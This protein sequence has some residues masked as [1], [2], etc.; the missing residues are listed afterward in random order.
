V[1]WLT[2]NHNIWDIDSD[3][4]TDIKDVLLVYLKR[5]YGDRAIAQILT[6]SYL[7]GKSA[8]D[9][10]VMI[11]GNRD[12]MD[13]ERRFKNGEVMKPGEV[14][15]EYN[16][17]GELKTTVVPVDYRYIADR[18]KKK[19]GVDF[20][21]K[22]MAE[23][24]D[25]LM[26]GAESAIEK[27]IVETA[28]LMD[29]NLDH[30]GLHAA[31]VII[32]D[33]DDLAEYI[34]VAWDV[35]F[36]TWKTQCDMVQCES[37]HGLLKMDI[38]LLKTLDIVTYAL[39]L[40][41]KNH[42]NA[43]IDIDNLPFEKEVFK[44][45]YAKG[46][47]K[48]V[49][50]FE[51]GGMVKFL[52]QLQPTCIED[53]IAANAMYRPGPMD[54]IPDYVAAKH[55]GN[56]VYDCPELEPI[57]KETY[58]VIIYQ[59][60]VMRIFRDLAG[61]SMGRSDLVRRAMAKK[62]M[63]E[64]VAERKNF[65]YGNEKENIHGCVPVGIS[66]EAANKMFDKMLSFAAYA[67]NKSHAAVYSVTSYM[68]AWLKYHY[69]TEFYCAA[70]NF[71]G[72]QKEIPSII[73]DAKRHGIQIL[74][75]DVNKS[76][77]NFSTENG[78]VRFGLKFLAGANN[79][80]SAVVDARESGF[81]SFKAFVQAKPGKTIAEACILSGACD[82][83]AG[84]NPDKR[85]ALLA[86]YHELSD[87]YDAILS[88][89]ARIA[90]ATKDD[91]RQKAEEAY[92]NLCEQWDMYALPDVK[93]MNL[94]ERLS[95]EQK[96]TSVYFSG[97][98]LDG[99]EID[100]NEY[101]DIGTL[102]DGETVWIAAA[103]SDEKILKT[104]K[105]ALPM[106]SGRLTD[107]TGSVNFII[108]PR[109]YEKIA[110]NLQTVMAFQGRMSANGDEEPQFVVSNVKELPQ[111]NKRIIVWFDDYEATKEIIRR[112]AVAK[113]DGMEAFLAGKNSKLYR[114]GVSITEEY[115]QANGLN[116]KIST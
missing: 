14:K 30:T 86:A 16:A 12:T 19:T 7:Q 115:A 82:A 51:S 102:E 89:E 1:F 69:P 68:T 67:F 63:D 24:R 105:D 31:G 103:V 49:F 11:L 91:V 113:S 9:K 99:F 62:H 74:K 114:V 93:P 58:G 106:M 18:L 56:I 71:V 32:S 77:A 44:N 112:G 40:I 28:I 38:L 13:R 116:Y 72:A 64:L 98:P 34:P 4:R 78:N 26:A 3:F 39:R 70:L 15:K 107:L 111:K 10:V 47:T 109:V 84:N 23:N 92:K 6:K 48:A 42:P 55:S 94:M 45:I 88:A 101:K 85:N 87:K 17:K 57:L 95:E 97:N 80:A 79:R 2:N 54:S 22:S 20:D 60:Q 66:E 46:D 53:I 41:K 50:Q 21:S 61:Y 43:K 108:F 73:A 52:R 5:K 65:I 104:K 110:A 36:E 75:P 33:N 59:E 37:K 81:K 96:Y 8:I 27:E 35:G 29:G 76:E 25:A 100:P 83:Y 90:A